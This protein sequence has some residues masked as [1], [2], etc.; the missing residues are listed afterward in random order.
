M[1]WDQ[2]PE[3]VVRIESNAATACITGAMEKQGMGRMLK[4]HF[5][6]SY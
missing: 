1:E 3:A 4:E 6:F 2:V 5:K